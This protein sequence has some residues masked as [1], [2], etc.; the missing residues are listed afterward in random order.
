MTGTQI[1]TLAQSYIDDTIEDTDALLW[2]NECLAV[3]LGID[4]RALV[5][6]SITA[7]DTTAWY[8]LPADF[9]AIY[10]VENSDGEEYS[11]DYRERNKKVRFDVTGTYTVWYWKLPTEVSALTDTPGAHTLLHRPM[12][13]FLGA[14]FKQK[15]DDE[16]PDAARL[17]A[18]YQ[19]KKRH[20]LT[21]I[22]GPLQ[23][24]S[25][26]IEVV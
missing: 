7:A 9:I 8:D 25:F 18:E 14:R 1:K 20:A 15:D 17:M 12:A 21:Q 19:Q 10:E 11:G 16:N 5:S 22:N 23:D 26:V 4:A 13:L 3:D 2:L 24:G 6:T